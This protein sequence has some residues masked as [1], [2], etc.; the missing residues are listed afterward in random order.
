MIS[1]KEL[2]KLYDDAL[3]IRNGEC[4]EHFDKDEPCEICS[5]WNKETGSCGLLNRFIELSKKM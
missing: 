3:A 1:K 2:K 5:Q 4:S